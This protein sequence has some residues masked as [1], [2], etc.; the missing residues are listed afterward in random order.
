MR[1]HL[2]K[3]GLIGNPQQ[4]QPKRHHANQAECDIKGSTGKVQSSL[5]DGSDASGK[6]GIDGSHNNQASPDP[7]E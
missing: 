3:S 4:A 2:D 5:R 1:Q 6:A 7:T